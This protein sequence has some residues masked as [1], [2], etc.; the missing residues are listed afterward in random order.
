MDRRTDRQTNRYIIDQ[1]DGLMQSQ[2]DGIVNRCRQ[3]DRLMDAQADE[4]TEKELWDRCRDKH[5]DR[6]TYGNKNQTDGR[7]DKQT[8]GEKK[9]TYGQ[10]N[11]WSYG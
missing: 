11:I 10:T 2:T 1:M 3:K 4:Q 7:M 9:Q 6:Q 8:D 5:I